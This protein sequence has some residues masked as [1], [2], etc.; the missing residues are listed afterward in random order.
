MCVPQMDAWRI[1]RKR[2]SKV[3]MSVCV[4]V[5]V[6]WVMCIFQM[7][8][9]I[10]CVFCVWMQ[11]KTLFQGAEVCIL[12]HV[13]RL[14]DVHIS[15]VWTDMYSIY[16]V[17][18]IWIREK[19]SFTVQMCVSVYVRVN[20]GRGACISNVWTNN[21]YVLHIHSSDSAVPKRGCVCPCMCV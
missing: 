1:R 9:P 7:Y 12:V 10:I 14:S 13:C 2:Y 19:R 21:I 5:F 11:A 6:D 17:L 18:Y 15:D 4:Y 8:E 16:D 3:P 20:I